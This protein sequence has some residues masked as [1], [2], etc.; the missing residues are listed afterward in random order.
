MKHQEK[1]PVQDR[2]EVHPS[3]VIFA[4][5]APESK[6]F[7]TMQARAA[8]A[9]WQLHRCGG[10]YVLHRWNRAIDCADLHAVRAALARVG[11][12]T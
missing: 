7:A 3:S 9:G 10:I 2:G 11:V 12:L 4:E 5:P 8:L 6:L 1:A